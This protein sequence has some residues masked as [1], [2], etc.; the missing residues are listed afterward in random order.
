[1]DDVLRYVWDSAEMRMHG[2]GVAAPDIRTLKSSIATWDEWLPAW[3]ALAEQYESTADQTLREGASITAGED[4]WQA[5]I[6]WHYGQFLWFHRPDERRE[7]QDRKVALYKKSSG[8]LSPPAERIDIPFEGTQIPAY[9]RLP[10]PEGPNPCVILLG[11]LESTKEESY[12]FENACLRRGLA[13]MAFDGPGQ[14]EYFFQRPLVGDFE[15]YTS[16]VADYLVQ[17]PEIDSEKLAVIGRSLGGYYSVRSCVFDER[18]KACV[19]FGAL[20]DV[21]H[22]DDLHPLVQQGFRHI[23]G[24]A[25]KEEA[26]ATLE[27]LI[28][29]EEVAPRLETPLYLLH[30]ALDHLI[31]VS[32]AHR[33]ASLATRSEKKIVIE[34]DGGHCGHNIYHRV[35]RPMI[36]WVATR[37][38]D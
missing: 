38:S 36:D 3:S 14:G 32:Q 16:A 26:E 4:Y 12:H 27:K 33:L 10:D 23:T 6:C 34:P 19:A 29:L 8:L 11:G 2:D 1:V 18:F 21:K 15:R 9:L 22:I 37:L 35:R 31:P 7:A 30:G 17:R 28:D 13:T 5:A 24:I 25:D 20:F